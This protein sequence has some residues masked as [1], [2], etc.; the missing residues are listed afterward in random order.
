MG[1]WNKHGIVYG[2]IFLIVFAC[3]TASSSNGKLHGQ[4]HQVHQVH[5]VQWNPKLNLDS[6]ASLNKRLAQPWAF[7]LKVS[8]STGPDWKKK[9]FALMQN[10]VSYFELTSQGFQASPIRDQQM[11]GATCH[12]LKALQEAAQPNRSFLSDFKFDDHSVG[13]LPPN[14]GLIISKEDVRRIQQANEAGLSWAQAETLTNVKVIKGQKLVVEGE[15]WGVRL[16]IYAK[17]DFTNDGI[18]DLL[19]MTHGWMTGG[20][21]QAIRLVLLTASKPKEILTLV[22]EYELN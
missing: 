21:Y 7:P 5:Q 3:P 4:I 14:V 11:E 20:T 13:R 17:G 22:K 12:A 1:S 19:I 18:E 9:E 10:C 16:E 6:L 8:R 15:G 2:F